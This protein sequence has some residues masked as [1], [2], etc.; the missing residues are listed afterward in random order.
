M[1]LDVKNVA[2]LWCGVIWLGKELAIGRQHRKALFTTMW[3]KERKNIE[4]V[5][6]RT[7]ALARIRA[8]L[9][10]FVTIRL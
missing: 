8:H 7:A 9:C 4:N 10:A 1:P 6:G 5:P 2:M 3:E